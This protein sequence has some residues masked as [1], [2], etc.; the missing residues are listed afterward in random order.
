MFAIRYLK[1]GAALGMCAAIV[2]IAAITACAQVEGSASQ[3]AQAQTQTA[4][5]KPAGSCQTPDG[6]L[7]EDSTIVHRCAIPGQTVTGCPLYLCRR[8]N[9]GTW[10]N[11]YSCPLR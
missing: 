3:P 11:E 5:V 1:S 7:V 6:S 2:A 10:S 4:A 8:C 9:G